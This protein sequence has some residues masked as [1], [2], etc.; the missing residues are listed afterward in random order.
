MNKEMTKKISR[1]TV[2]FVDAKG[3]WQVLVG[4][5]ERY[6]HSPT[7]RELNELTSILVQVVLKRILM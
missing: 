4:A 6:K 5:L 1:F 3:Q 2:R 7:E